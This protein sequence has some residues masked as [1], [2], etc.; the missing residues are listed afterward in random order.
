MNKKRHKHVINVTFWLKMWHFFQPQKLHSKHDNEKLNINFEDFSL[1]C[2]LG[3]T[4]GLGN[5]LVYHLQHIWIRNYHSSRVFTSPRNLNSLSPN[6]VKK[7]KFTH[8]FKKDKWQKTAKNTQ[9]DSEKLFFE[10]RA[11][12]TNLCHRTKHSYVYDHTQKQF[13]KTSRPLT[14]LT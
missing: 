5:T 1:V 4:N 10:T 7:W 2:D 12:K 13:W 14:H 8:K 3:K 11:T 6:F 9:H